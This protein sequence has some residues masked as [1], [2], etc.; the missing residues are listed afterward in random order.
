MRSKLIQP[1]KRCVPWFAYADIATVAL[2]HDDFVY[3]T[4]F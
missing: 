3:D 1:A 2:M 4:A